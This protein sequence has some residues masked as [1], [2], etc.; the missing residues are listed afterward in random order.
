M[1][2]FQAAQAIGIA[3]PGITI[4][5]L[6][7][8]VRAVLTQQTQVEH[9]F[10][11]TVRQIESKGMRPARSRLIRAN[12]ADIRAILAHTVD[13]P[14]HATLIDVVDGCGGTGRVVTRVDG[15]ATREECHSQYVTTS[16]DR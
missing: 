8:R 4:G 14:H 10:P 5:I 11:T 6:P 7:A 15:W 3:L 9:G 12:I 1:M 2:Q 16:K 13:G